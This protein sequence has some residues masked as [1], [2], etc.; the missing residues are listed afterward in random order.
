MKKIWIFAIVV[1]LFFCQ[2][3]LMYVLYDSKND[4]FILAYIF[5]IASFT[6]GADALSYVESFNLVYSYLFVSVA[7]AVAMVLLYHFLDLP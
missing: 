5:F 4:L 1:Y 6:G 7:F 2:A 3:Y